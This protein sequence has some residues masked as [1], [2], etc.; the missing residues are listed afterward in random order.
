MVVPPLSWAGSHTPRE[1]PAPPAG[2]WQRNSP[3]IERDHPGEAAQSGSL[4]GSFLPRI[5]TGS[6]KSI[7]DI[8]GCK[9]PTGVSLPCTNSNKVLTRKKS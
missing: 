9:E 4:R 2:P 8:I 1:G 5:T 6:L 3:G 7:Q